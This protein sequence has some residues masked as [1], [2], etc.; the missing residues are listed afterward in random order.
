MLQI[1]KLKRFVPITQQPP[2]G[3]LEYTPAGPSS[4]AGISKQDRGVSPDT[5]CYY[6]SDNTDSETALQLR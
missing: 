6:G 4:S 3:F 1:E 5:V 2:G